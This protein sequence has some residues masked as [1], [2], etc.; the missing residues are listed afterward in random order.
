MITSFQQ[1]LSVH[2]EEERVFLWQLDALPDNV[3][4]MVGS[5]LIGHE[6]PIVRINVRYKLFNQLNKIN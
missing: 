1:A 5:Q 3:V 4:E 6:I 2:E